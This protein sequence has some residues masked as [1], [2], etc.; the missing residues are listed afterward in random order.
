MLSSVHMIKIKNTFN[1]VLVVVLA[2]GGLVVIPWQHLVVAETCPISPTDNQLNRPC[3]PTPAPDP[4]LIATY[5]A[6]IA[7]KQKQIE[8][9]NTQ[10]AT[11][12]QQMDNTSGQILSLKTE[13]SS[14]DNQI[15]LTNIEIQ[16]KQTKI[17]SLEIEIRS[18]QASIEQ[19]TADVTAK[20]ILLGDAV[21][22]LD[23]SSRTTTL[24]L[25]LQTG[26]FNDFYSQAQAQAEI[27]I[28]LHSVISDIQQAR[29]ELETKQT[30]LSSVKD[31]VQQ[32]KLQF[33]D[34]KQAVIEQ[35]NYQ[36]G[37]LSDT[38]KSA[39][40]YALLL[41]GSEGKVDDVQAQ[42]I[43]IQ[44]ALQAKLN[45]SDGLPVDLP[46]PSGFIWPVSGREINAGFMDPRYGLNSGRHYGIDIE[47]DQGDY[48]KATADGIV[49]KVDPPTTGIYPSVVKIQHGGN[50][51]TLYL[52]LHEIFVAN[53]Q[54]IKQGDI[55]GRSGGTC[56]TAGAGKCGWF[57]TGSHLHYEMHI[58]NIPVNPLL[59]LP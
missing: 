45:A 6:Q 9:L 55:I 53:G 52:H 19:K 37:L 8:D 17:E 59:Y 46:S 51:D 34:Q 49:R 41:A 10:A 26:S 30:G 11:Y 20:R 3:D 43:Q 7:E 36:D 31:E 25:V 50:F 16:S 40:Q 33:Q 39:Q 24:A 18:L 32:Q 4:D 13:L 22:E 5:N 29:R 2:F 15:A 58:N 48:V 54:S 38:K 44:A 42:I 12:Q 56:Y 21:R 28:S 23:A 27:S 47:T 57:T 35:K 1:F 14:I